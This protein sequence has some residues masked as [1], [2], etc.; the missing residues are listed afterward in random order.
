MAR[1]R[2]RA[3]RPAPADFAARPDRR[4]EEAVRHPGRGPEPAPQAGAPPS[5]RLRPRQAAHRGGGPGLLGRDQAPGAPPEAP[6]PPAPQDPLIKEGRVFAILISIMAK[7][8]A[9]TLPGHFHK[10]GPG[11]L[12]L[13]DFARWYRD[14]ELAQWQ[15]PGPPPG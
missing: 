6:G 1:D 8:I 11:G 14:Q 7:K 2:R 5:A 12:G 13:R 9:G 15:A 3:G 10:T 4:G